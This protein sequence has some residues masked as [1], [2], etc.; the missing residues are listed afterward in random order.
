MSKVI[1]EFP[2]DNSADSF[3]AW[4]TDCG[5]EYDFL[6][7]EDIAAGDDDRPPIIKFTYE[8]AFSSH[9]YDPQKHGDDPTVVAHYLEEDKSV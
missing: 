3:L 2:D 4:F 7:G 9:G 5:G 6:K 8:K 1:F